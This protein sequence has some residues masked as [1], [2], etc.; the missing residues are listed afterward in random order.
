MKRLLMARADHRRRPQM[1][2]VELLVHLHSIKPSATC[3]PAASAP[4]HPS[5]ARAK[6]W[7]RGHP[8][9]PRVSAFCVS[10][11]AIAEVLATSGFS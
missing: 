9:C 7:G 6:L 4:A 8:C 2:P 10:G 3:G 5:R 11:A 1:A